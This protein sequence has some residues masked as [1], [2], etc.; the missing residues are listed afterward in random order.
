MG[1]GRKQR[2]AVMK[3]FEGLLERVEALLPA[4]PAGPLADDVW[5]WR[6]RRSRGIGGLRAVRHLHDI[7]LAELRGVERQKT[8][9][10]RN[11]RQLLAGL[12]ANNAL[13]WGARGTGKSSLVKALLNAYGPRG[14]RVVEVDREEL[15]D[16]PEI[17][18]LLQGRPERFIIFSDDLSFEEGDASFKALKGILDGS[19]AAVP[20]NV[21]IYATSNRRHLVS[22]YF[23]ENHQAR[24]VD[25]EIHHAEAVEEKIS[26]AERFG[27]WLSFYPFDQDTYLGIVGGWLETL[28]FHDPDPALTRR[29]A[30]RWALGR[31]SRSGRSAHQ[32]ARDWVGR[33]A[34]E[35]PPSPPTEEMSHD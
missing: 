13:L 24:N 15:A 21:L 12:P 28:G 26:L 11:T 18:D 14:L 33:H 2:R 10:E 5:A 17:I 9:L 4:A 25:G 3:R 32:F 8:L 29:E 7:G 30:L 20:A 23:A 19:V 16:L 35:A 27:L 31:G 6:W 34:L 22:E 1:D